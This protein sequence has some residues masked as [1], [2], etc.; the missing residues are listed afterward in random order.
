MFAA[1]VLSSVGSLF[2]ILVL[3]V[4]QSVGFNPWST[5]ASS[6]ALQFVPLLLAIPVA[7]FLFVIATTRG[8]DKR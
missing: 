8:Q 2:A 7:G 1:L 6:I 5:V 4:M 3:F